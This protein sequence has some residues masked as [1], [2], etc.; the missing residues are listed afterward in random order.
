MKLAALFLIIIIGLA[1]IF[2]IVA[3][4]LEVRSRKPTYEVLI[5]ACYIPIGIAGAILAWLA[6]FK[7]IH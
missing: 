1:A 2:G 6:Y 5:K 7:I 4:V 3:T